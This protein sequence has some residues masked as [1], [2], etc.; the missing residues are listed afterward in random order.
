MVRLMDGYLVVMSVD[1]TEVRKETH[2][3]LMKAENSADY[4]ARMKAG[5][6]VVLLEMKLEI[7][8]QFS[9]LSSYQSRRRRRLLPELLH[10]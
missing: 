8:S 5:R 7:Q 3:A 6:M 4:S 9:S 2:L 1:L 10:C